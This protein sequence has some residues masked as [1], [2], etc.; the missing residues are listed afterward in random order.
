MDNILIEPFNKLHLT[1]DRFCN[2]GGVFIIGV[3]DCVNNG[4]LRVMYAI[5]TKP[6]INNLNLILEDYKPQDY[7]TVVYDKASEGYKKFYSIWKK[8]EIK[9]SD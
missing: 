1:A 8:Y 2:D 3:F 6:E 4:L 9:Y 5:Y 7:I